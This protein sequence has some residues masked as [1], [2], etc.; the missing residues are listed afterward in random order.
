MSAFSNLKLGF[1]SHKKSV[2]TNDNSRR[3]LTVTVVEAKGLKA[4]NKSPPTSDPFGVI[5]LV[6]L[7]GREIKTESNK[8][9]QKS[10]TTIPKFDE[11]FVFGK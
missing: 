10:G 4:R 9:K 6:D 5:N 11:T 8:I 7:G 3:L 2:S 1:P